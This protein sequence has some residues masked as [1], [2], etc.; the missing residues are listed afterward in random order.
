MVA[1]FASARR[2]L[3]SSGLAGSTPYA[4]LVRALMRGALACIVSVAIE[5]SIKGLDPRRMKKP[6]FPRR[7]NQA[8]KE[9]SNGDLKPTRMWVVIL[10]ACCCEHETIEARDCKSRVGLRETSLEGS[11]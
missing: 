6:N 1:V 11:L 5:A 3:D 4:V 8:G 7:T 2:V 10:I 9:N